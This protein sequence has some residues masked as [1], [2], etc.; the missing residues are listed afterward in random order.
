MP[1]TALVSLV[2]GLLLVTTAA[3][4]EEPRSR[5]A[6]PALSAAERRALHGGHTVSRPVRFS[7][8]EDTRYV[9]GVSYQVVRAT[10]REVLLALA[11]VQALPQ[12]LPHTRS[13]ELLSSSGHGARVEL[14]QGKAP[15]L[16]TYTIQLE[17]APDGNEIR[18]WLDPRRPHGVRDV[19]GFFRV[20]EFGPGRTL[21]T[22]AVALDLGPG[23]ARLFFE[24]RVEQ[25]ILR[26]PAK[27]REF[28]EP[29]ALAAVP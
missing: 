25:A 4:G 8:G 28:V 14:V 11:D 6:R 26:A 20:R 22:V 21:I 3:T 24:D 9:G 27:I 13:A 19:W 10:P 7:D 5:G 12:A 29:R 18:F 16:V 1:R 23:L 15:F 17:Q 2:V